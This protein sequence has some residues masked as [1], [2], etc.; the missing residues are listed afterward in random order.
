MRRLVRLTDDFLVLLDTQLPAERTDAAPSRRD[1]EVRDLLRIVDTFAES[2]DWLAPSYRGRTEY[3]E[4]SGASDL[5]LAIW[6]QGQLAPDG[7]IELIGL[8]LDIAPPWVG[9]PDDD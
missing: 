2:W 6:V 9:E 7:A 1:F 5:G 4:W 3:R 8:E